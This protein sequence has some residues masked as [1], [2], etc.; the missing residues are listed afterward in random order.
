MEAYVGMVFLKPRKSP[1][2]LGGPRT[3]GAN[4]RAR[5]APG[6]RLPGI[7][8]PSHRLLVSAPPS[9][10]LRRTRVARR[11]RAEVSRGC[12]WV[13]RGGR[14]ACGPGW[15]CAR[16]ASPR[17]LPAPSS[18]APGG[19]NGGVE[20]S[21]EA[22][23]GGRRSS[24]R[25]RARHRRRAG[26]PGGLPA[27]RPGRPDNLALC[28]RRAPPRLLCGGF[29]GVR[30][31]PACGCGS[32]AR[33]GDPGVCRRRVRGCSGPSSTRRLNTTGASRRSWNI[34]MLVFLLTY[35]NSTV[36]STH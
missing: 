30:G 24:S 4:G 10:S 32:P 33:P 2:D 18:A 12:G 6:R 29:G 9:G 13:R 31:P 34:L 5:S 22:R 11:S 23:G 20:Q 28:S 27:P 26:P 14:P 19:Q 35:T 36:Y 21:S 8:C 7:G 3:A 16:P 1:K 17:A 15:G 25:G